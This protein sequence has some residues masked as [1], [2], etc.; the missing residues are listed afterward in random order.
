MANIDSSIF[1]KLFQ[2]FKEC[3]NLYVLTWKTKKVTKA[4]MFIWQYCF[5]NKYII[6]T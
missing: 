5:L 1:G 4:V 2:I 3:E 6:N